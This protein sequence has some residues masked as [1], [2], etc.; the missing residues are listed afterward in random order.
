MISSKDRSGWIGASDTDYVIGNWGTESFKKWWLVK[1]G[2][3]ENN[4]ENLSM[5]AGTHKEHQILEFIGCP[6]TD[7]QILIPDKR[8]R[9]NLDGNDSECIYEVKTH[10][11]E[12][13]FR[14]PIKYKRQVWVQLYATGY[15]KAFIVAYGLIEDDFRNYFLP[16]DENRL[17]KFPITPNDDFIENKYIPRLEILTDCLIKG[18]FPPCFK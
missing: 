11:A 4:Y 1:L 8:L 14:V 15:K 5:N 6:E 16:I 7:K 2:I 12:K 10:K 13:E 9:V 3:K 18:V 17:S